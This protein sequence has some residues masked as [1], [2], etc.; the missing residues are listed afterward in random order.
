[1]YFISYRVEYYGNIDYLINKYDFMKM[2]IM[3]HLWSRMLKQIF[4]LN[5]WDLFY[6]AQ[7]W[8][9]LTILAEAF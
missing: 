4:S 3:K 1:M 8:N 6:Q 5:I 7:A 9:P 2:R